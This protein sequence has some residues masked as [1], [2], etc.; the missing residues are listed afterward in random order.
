VRRGPWDELELASEPESLI[1]VR[2]G[3]SNDRESLSLAIREAGWYPTIGESFRAAEDADLKW[4]WI[5]VT[6]ESTVVI[7]GPDG[8]LV[9]T[10][11]QL[12]DVSQVTLAR[13][14]N[15]A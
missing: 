10:G 2:P 7:C 1:L 3:W 6:D 8:I 14:S 12:V 9:E 5:G 11:E 13:I 15:C 4:G